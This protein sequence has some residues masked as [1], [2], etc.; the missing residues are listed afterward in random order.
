[1]KDTS[2]IRTHLL[3]R[4]NQIARRVWL[5]VFIF[6]LAFFVSTY[7]DLPAKFATHF[8]FNGQPNG[9][10]TKPFYLGLFGSLLFVS[11]GLLFA[12]Q[13]FR[14]R[15]RFNIY[16]RFEREKFGNDDEIRS[17][18][19]PRAT[20]I[21]SVTGIFINFIFC[22]CIQMIAQAATPMPIQI[23]PNGLLISIL[24]M[25]VLLTVISAK[26]ARP[27]KRATNNRI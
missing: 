16:R 1:M 11:N 26:I 24:I 7:V 14:H 22:A 19:L 4:P 15:V 17:E 6:C 21:L 12:L 13:A 9:W 25:T 27:P 3:D 2:L 5:V 23:A 10:S 18:V 20:L 8:D